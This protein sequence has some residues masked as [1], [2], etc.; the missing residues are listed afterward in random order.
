LGKL[1]FRRLSPQDETAFMAALE[2]WDNSP[3]FQFARDY[4]PTKNFQA[5]LTYLGKKERG[6]DLPEGFV[7]ETKLFAFVGAD[8][9]GNLSLRHTLNDFLLKIGGHIGYGVMPSFRRMGYAKAMLQQ[10]LPYAKNLGL[11]RV[12]LTC[13]DNNLGSI[14]T[15]EACG[16]VIEN[17]V[18]V[19]EGKPLK[20]R[21]WIAI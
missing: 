14:K 2:T 16:G 7:P 1:I 12:L 17:K 15:I 11:A 10:S 3:G 5:Y 19:E 4:D 18:M 13:D 8:L 6:E 21:Y 9:V 20:R